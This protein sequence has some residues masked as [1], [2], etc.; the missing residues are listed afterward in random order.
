MTFLLSLFMLHRGSN[1]TARLPSLIT[2]GF[3]ILAA[4]FTTIVFLIDVIL[5]AVVRNHVKNDTDND[6]TLNWGN[7]VRPF[8]S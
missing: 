2:L 8:C 6:V 4:L 7:A 1:G 5:V 3:G